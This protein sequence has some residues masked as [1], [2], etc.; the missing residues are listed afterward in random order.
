MTVIAPDHARLLSTVAGACAATGAN[1][2]DAQVFTTADGMALDTIYVS[3]AF[4]YDEDELRRAGNI[5]LAIERALSGQVKLR[6]M[7]AA[8]TRAAGERPQCFS[9]PSRSIDRQFAFQ[10][11]HRS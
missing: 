5:V 8:K 7:V 9:Y 4:K 10:P 11:L 6:D 3:R 1:I 2:V